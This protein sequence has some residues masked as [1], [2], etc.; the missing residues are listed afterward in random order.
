MLKNLLRRLRRLMMADVL[1][2]LDVIKSQLAQK[3]ELAKQM[4]AALLTIAL[5]TENA[6]T[7]QGQTSQDALNFQN[8]Q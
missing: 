6:E 5:C 2:E 4:E 3:D 1:A 8:V 7:P